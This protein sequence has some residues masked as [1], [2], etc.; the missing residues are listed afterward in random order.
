MPA[1]GTDGSCLRSEPLNC[2]SARPGGPGR[3]RAERSPGLAHEPSP[4]RSAR[5]PSNLAGVTVVIVDDDPDTRDLYATILTACGA[6]VAEAANAR[7]ALAVIA[8]RRPHVVVSD[9]AMPEGDGYWLIGELRR[10]DDPVL[11][12]LPVVAVT[13]FGREHSRDRVLAGGFVEHLQKPVEPETLC[14]T[15]GRAAG[16]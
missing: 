14:R 12:R 11:S 1:S 7:D 4:R 2:P 15:I 16:R 9:I 6:A 13:A 8:E 5:L 3:E 10:V